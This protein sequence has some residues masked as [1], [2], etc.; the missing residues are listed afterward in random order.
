MLGEWA[1][2]DLTAIAI[3]KHTRG[4]R[5][6]LSGNGSFDSNDLGYRT[7]EVHN[8]A[9]KSW[10]I[11]GNIP[12][13]LDVHMQRVRVRSKL[14][15]INSSTRSYTLHIQQIVTRV[16]SLAPRVAQRETLPKEHQICQGGGLPNL[17]YESW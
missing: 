2:P 3:N 11:A 7:R 9:T 8:S 12:A 1:E 15:S 10:S 6:A 4:Y 13:N 17:G 16:K 14:S 5:L